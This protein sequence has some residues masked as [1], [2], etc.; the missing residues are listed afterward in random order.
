MLYIFPSLGRCGSTLL[1]NLVRKSMD[2]D[3]A[4]AETFDDIKRFKGRLIKTHSAFTGNLEIEWKAVFIYADIAEIIASLYNIKK[5]YRYPGSTEPETWH[6]IHLKNLGV[7]KKHIV[8]FNFLLS[9]SRFAAFLFLV[10]GDKYGFSEKVISWKKTGNTL[11]V[12]YNDLTNKK[13]KTMEKISKYLNVKLEDFEVKKRES[14]VNEL[15]LL[16]KK[17]IQFQY[18]NIKKIINSNQ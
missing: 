11:F 17:V 7:D 6:T 9:F 10:I 12:N 15:P 4:W 14:S 18:G 16:L 8:V 1:Y 2:Q 5:N 3:W 13:H